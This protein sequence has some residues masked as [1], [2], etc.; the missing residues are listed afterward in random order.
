MLDWVLGRRKSHK[1]GPKRK[2]PSYEEAKRIAQHGD[3]TARADLAAHEELEP[4]FLYLFATDDA[5][6]VRRAVAENDGTPLQADLILARDIDPKVREELAYKIGRLIP[7]LTPDESERLADMAFQVLEILAKDQ[8]PTIRAIV[9][10]EIKH[11]HN[12]PR[13][14]VEQL[15]RDVEDAV[16]GPILE[17]SPLLNAD[18]LLQIVASGLRGGALEALARRQGLSAELSQAIVGQGADPATAEL[19][20]NQTA[21]ISQK[22]MEEIAIDAETRP[23]LHLPLVDRG[24]L[25]EGTIRRIATFV[26][27]ALLE[28][29]I[30]VNGLNERVAKEIRLAVRERIDASGEKLGDRRGDAP[31]EVADDGAE[32]AEQRHKAGKLDDDAILDAIDD[33]DLTFLRRAFEL[34]SG[35]KSQQVDKMLKSGSAKG[36]CALAWKA[37]LGADIAVSLQRRIGKLPAK[38]MIQEAPTG[39][40]QMS[41]EEL[42]WYVDYF[43]A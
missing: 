19:L 34:M 17:Y 37:G 4:E 38:S 21:E 2:K 41:E 3:A 9:A 8:L 1:A 13:R 29:L 10:D 43:A 16:A 11:L 42:K 30:A 20:R 24:S 6:E 5:V 28:R 7:T 27:A 36:L 15:A 33:D 31:I 35:L 12:V 14:I 26:S 39:G 25:S 32:R 22:L 40:Y 18:Q 23:E